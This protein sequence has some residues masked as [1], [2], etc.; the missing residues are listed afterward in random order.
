MAR[1]ASLDAV[2][3]VLDRYLGIYGDG[4]RTTR[5]IKARLA[6]AQEIVE[7]IESVH[8]HQLR[9]DLDERREDARRAR[10][11]GKGQP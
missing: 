6:L 7:Y 9:C 1:R 2:C 10:A 4:K 11:A 3:D 5:T 8:V